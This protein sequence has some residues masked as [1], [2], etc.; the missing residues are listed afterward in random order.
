MLLAHVAGL[1][2]LVALPLWVGTLVADYRLDF[3]HAG[4]TVTVFLLG[5]V[6][7]SLWFAPRFDRLSP[8]LCAIVGY[9][10]SAVGLFLVALCESWP[11]LLM[12]HIV[13]GIGTGCGLSMAHGAMGRSA[14]P[15]R[16]LALAGIVL[17][18]FAVSFYA[19]VPP[20]MGAAGGASVFLVMAGL[21]AC[22]AIASLRFPGDR[23][24]GRHTDRREQPG[25][26]SPLRWPLVIGVACL[27]LNQSIIFS[28][29]ERIGMGR[30]FGREHVNTVLAA[31]GIVNLFP[32]ALAGMLQKRLPAVGVAIATASIQFGLAVTVSSSTVF[33]PYA[34][35]AALYA[36][37][38]IFAHP[39]LFGLTARIDPSGRTNALTPAMLMTGSALAPALGGAVAQRLGFPGLGVAVFAI[40]AVALL[41]FTWL[42]RGLKHLEFH[43]DTQQL[44]APLVDRSV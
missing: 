32:S 38:M 15:H 42:G 28:F 7:A 12:L 13:A 29:L 6:C 36:A 9:A 18:V 35:A 39:F 40:S 26:S 10:V 27:A 25:R 8:R 34:L 30:G 11:P 16:L 1:I 21:M 20:L 4:M 37:M 24:P 19:L 23:K 17:G 43:A 5:V 22:A 44:S 41:C 2:D 14:N 33:A 31:I 3:E